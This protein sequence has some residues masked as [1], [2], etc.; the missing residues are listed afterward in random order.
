MGHLIE[1]DVSRLTISLVYDSSVSVLAR[2]W[3]RRNCSLP[4]DS[5]NPV[6]TTVRASD[7]AIPSKDVK[8]PK[9]EGFLS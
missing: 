9:G 8:A 1:A 3:E 2:R 6:I 7:T 5:G 4:F